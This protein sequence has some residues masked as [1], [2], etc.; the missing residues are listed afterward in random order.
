MAITAQDL[1]TN[2]TR[3]KVDLNDVDNDL[4]LQWCDYLNKEVYRYVIQVDPM[5]FLSTTNYTVSSSP[6]AQNLPS[7]F[8]TIQV[9]GCGL[10]AVYNGIPFPIPLPVTYYGATV[11]GYYFQ[12]SQIVFTGFNTSTSLVLRY[13]PGLTTIDE[14]TDTFILPDEYLSTLERL[15]DR[16]YSIWDEDPEAEFLADERYQ[17]ALSELLDDITRG[18]AVYDISSLNA[19]YS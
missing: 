4:F 9:L 6:S 3:D 8:K 10:Y 11:P 12:G 15:V 7:D 17:R 19:F 5:R 13:I 18:P 1:L 2:Y 16:F 14:L